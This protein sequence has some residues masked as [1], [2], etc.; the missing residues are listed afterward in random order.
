M[1]RG[2]RRGVAL[3]DAVLGGVMLAVGLAVLLS[4]ASRS[5]AMQTAGEKRIAAA[6]LVDEL[7]SMT[8]V[9]GPDVYSQL[10]P[11]QGRFEPPFDEFSFEVDIEDIG[12]R[13]PRLVT[14]TVR[15]PHGPGFREVQAQTYIAVREGDPNQER[16]PLEP[17][18]RLGRYY[19]DEE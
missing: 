12:P 1:V 6:W 4:L 14:A 9:E 18:D 8:L 11:T 3:I 13:K 17:I 16:A 10:H 19:D 2:G 5:V 7:L 15:W